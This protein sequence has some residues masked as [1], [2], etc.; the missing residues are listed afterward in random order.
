VTEPHDPRSF[1]RPESVLVIIHTAALQCLLLERVEPAGFW[2]SVTGTLHWDE[3]PAAA[4]AREVREETGI[5]PTGLR[6]AAVTRRFPILPAWRARYAPDV[7]E[8]TEHL[9]YLELPERQPVT[10]DPAEH[11]AYRWLPIDFAIDFATSWTNREGL[12]RLARERSAR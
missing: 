1:R 7:T 11:R 3:T 12:E 4:A 10:L 5:D 8:N 6:D 2:Q 9:W